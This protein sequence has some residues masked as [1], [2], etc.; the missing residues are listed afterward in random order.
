[1]AKEQHHRGAM[2]WWLAVEAWLRRRGL[3][4]VRQ[5]QDQN[6]STSSLRMRPYNSV[7]LTAIEGSP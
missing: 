2:L 6:V 1:M 3:I 4:I 7:G 5:Y